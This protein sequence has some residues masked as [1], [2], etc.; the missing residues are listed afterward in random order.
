MTRGASVLFD[1]NYVIRVLPAY[2]Q[3]MGLTLKLSIMGIFFA[4]FIGMLCSLI[5]FYRIKIASS[6]VQ[7][8]VAFFRNTP[9]VIQLF[10]I[11]YGLPKVGLTLSA[12]WV[13]ILGLS[14]IGGSYMTEAFGG[15]IGAVSRTQI[16]S[17][18]SLGLS[19]TQ[20]ARYVIFPQALSYSVPALSANCIFLLKET[21]VFSVITLMELMNTTKSLNGLY[22]KSN[23]SYFMLVVAYML[24]LIPL[25]LMFTA[26]E[27]KVRYAEFGH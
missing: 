26:L 16:E 25:S 17:G 24:L 21:S 5:L 8:Y 12:E 4:I 23:E 20:L 3:A 1:W 18:I 19:K 9:L 13:A 14:L 22:Y 6:I 7:A 10:F 2:Q 15:G 11:F 27:K